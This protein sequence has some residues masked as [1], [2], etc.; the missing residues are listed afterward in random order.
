MS[1]Q[2]LHRK[3]ARAELSRRAFI[4]SIAFVT[5]LVVGALLTLSIQVR[6]TQIEGTPTGQK[7]LT[8]SDRILDCTDPKGECYQRSQKRTADVVAA[9]NLGA[10]YGAYCVQ[11]NPRSTLPEIKA[12]VEELYAEDQ[13][14]QGDE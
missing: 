2:D 7:L 4:V 13:A 11:Q 10:I 1:E 14:K 9:L 12:C 8:A 3:L 6:Q 5:A